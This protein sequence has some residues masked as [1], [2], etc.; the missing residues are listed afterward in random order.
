MIRQIS[1]QPQPAPAPAQ[2]WSAIQK[3]AVNLGESADHR[4]HIDGVRWD[5]ASDSSGKLI[6]EGIF[7]DAYLDPTK[8]K[9]VYLCIKPLTDQPRNL[10][11]HAL[12]EFQFED[13][14]PVTNSQGGKVTPKTSTTQ[15]TTI[16]Y[17]ALSRASINESAQSR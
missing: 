10:P 13:D 3:E 5:I 16:A 12:L 11:G 2:P 8:V 1:A 15:P 7:S 6:E 14:A 9:D 17:R 4:V